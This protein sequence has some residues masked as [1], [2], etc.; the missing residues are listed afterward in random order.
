VIGLLML[1]DEQRPRLIL[2][3]FRGPDSVEHFKGMNHP[4]TRDAVETTGRAIGHILD[5]IRSRPWASRATLIVTTDH[6][7]IN[8]TYNV[9]VQKIL[10]NHAIKARFLST[11]STS[12]LYFDDPKEIDHAFNALSEYGQMFDVVRKEAQ[13]R[14]WHIGSSPRVGD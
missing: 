14:D 3:Y 8:T 1:P 9:N 2:A 13:P 12:F 11:G 10:A 4:D 7:M 5:T 6:G